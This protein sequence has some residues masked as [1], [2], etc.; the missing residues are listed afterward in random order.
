M[1][2]RLQT[3]PMTDYV[4]APFGIFEL[5]AGRPPVLHGRDGATQYFG[6]CGHD[7]TTKEVRE[8]PRLTPKWKFISEQEARELLTP[9]Q[10]D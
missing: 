6:P 4:Q 10:G 1:A 5:R 8:W 9:D 2:S 7:Y 3:D